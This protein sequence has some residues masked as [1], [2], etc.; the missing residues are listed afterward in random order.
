[1]GCVTFTLKPL[2][3]LS[4]T[5]NAMGDFVACT[6]TLNDLKTLNYVGLHVMV[7][8][9]ANPTLDP[10]CEQGQ[11]VTV[12]NGACLD[13]AVTGSV[14]LQDRGNRLLVRVGGAGNLTS[15]IVSWELEITRSQ[16]GCFITDPGYGTCCTLQCRQGHRITENC[17]CSC[18]PGFSGPEC[19]RMLPYIEATY[20]FGNTS[21]GDWLAFTPAEL[22][23]QQHR[24]I[25]NLR[26]A[27]AALVGLESNHVE[28][29]WARTPEDHATRRAGADAGARCATA[30]FGSRVTSVT[31]RIV[32]PFEYNLVPVRRRLAAAHS[33][34]TGALA[35]LGSHVCL[36]DDS[37]A[38]FTS[39][40]ARIDLTEPEMEGAGGLGQSATLLFVFLA[41]GGLLVL[42]F[43]ALHLY[44]VRAEARDATRHLR[45]H[46]PIAMLYKQGS[47]WRYED[48][49]TRLLVAYPGDVSAAL[50]DAFVSGWVEAGRPTVSFVH[51]GAECEADFSRMRVTERP[52]VGQVQEVIDSCTIRLDRSASPVSQA[53]NGCILI[54]GGGRVQ[55]GCAPTPDP[56]PRPAPAPPHPTPPGVAT[57]ARVCAAP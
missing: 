46:K 36:L 10:T 33:N 3:A 32:V 13:E 8:V 27:L 42:A 9:N 21:L 43:L 12:I 14:A 23:P 1:M 30:V 18:A 50:Q 29:V 49:A 6:I 15:C 55:D 17:F 52:V 31:V 11:W 24:S 57:A 48:P 4:S 34:L 54:I 41:L 39:Y 20:V 5:Q 56:L 40:G 53:H 51:A 26:N 44:T 16:G 38:G 25:L 47:P 22:N 28:L 19:D 45:D 7:C 37:A 2:D 35:A